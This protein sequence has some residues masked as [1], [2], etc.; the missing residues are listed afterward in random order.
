MSDIQLCEVCNENPFKYKCPGCF[1]RT[2][3]LACSKNHK[4]DDNCT[5]KSYDPHK[6][7]SNEEI[8][9]ADDEKH[10]NNALIQRDFNFLTSLKREVELHKGDAFSKNRKTLQV[11]HK[12]S[13]N[14][15]NNMNNKRQ[16]VDSECQRVIRRGVNCLLLPRGMS[17]SSSNRSKWDKPLDLFVWSIEWIICPQKSDDDDISTEIFKH[18]SHRVKETDTVTDGM[19]N[20]VYEKCCKLYGIETDH[21]EVKGDDL[22]DKSS[23]EYREKR[24]HTLIEN[25]LKFYTKWFAYNTTQPTDSRELIELDGVTKC[26]GEQLKNRT[27]IEFP[28]VFIARKESDLPI[29]YKVINENDKTDEERGIRKS[30]YNNDI[31]DNVGQRQLSTT[32]PVKDHDDVED[33]DDAPEVNST[34][35]A[36]TETAPVPVEQSKMEIEDEENDDY[37]PAATF[38]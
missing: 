15:Y 22:V 2:C 24:A 16:K 17:R 20:I 3:S 28:T 35:L 38:K 7:V 1:K 12:N 31:N 36:Q 14:S 6:Y 13:N 21:T 18:I 5:G 37:D 33:D 30:R 29:G 34:T 25:K 11:Y 4:L 9:N 32:N 10:E 8:K 27:V 23:D 26:I 19:S